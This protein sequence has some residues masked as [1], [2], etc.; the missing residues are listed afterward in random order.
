MKNGIGKMIEIDL[1]VP[2]NENPRVNRHAV[3]AVAKSI[4]E[5]GFAAPIV[6]RSEDNMIICGHTRFLAAQQLKLDRIPV[7]FMDLSLE[8][9]KRL[10][11]ADNKT[12][13]LALWDDERLKELLSSFDVPDLDVLGFDDDELEEMLTIF[14]PPPA[15]DPIPKPEPIENSDFE[16]TLLKGDC[17]ETLKTLPDNSIDAIITDP[18]YHLQSIVD[19]FGGENAAESKYG[20]DGLFQRASKGFMGKTWDGGSIAFS[21]E[22]WEECLRVVKHGG[23]LCAF[24]STRTVFRMGVAIEDSG[25]M[26]RDMVSWIYASGFP[27]SLDISKAIDKHLGAERE[28]I[29]TKKQRGTISNISMNVRDSDV[30]YITK[31][32]TPEA[33]RAVG[34]G[35]ALKPAQEPCIIARKPIEGTNAENFLKYGTG[36]LNIDKARFPYGDPCWPFNNEEYVIN[37]HDDWKGFHLQQENQEYV[38]ESRRSPVGGRWPAN[39]YHCKKAQRSER[40]LGLEHLDIKERF[41]N[42]NSHNGTGKRVDGAPTPTAFNHHPTVKPVKLMQFLVSLVVPKGGIVLDPFGGSGTTAVAAAL[43]KDVKGAIICE[44][45]EE[46][47]ELIEGRVEHAKRIRAGLEDEE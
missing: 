32:A 30:E 12:G 45:T 33:Q 39:I 24:S 13:E 15:P 8:D 35:T 18:P 2:W 7:R 46:Y 31:P 5:F 47:F 36:G 9:A 43:D 17:L 29:G 23:Y 34:I 28:V 42:M 4:K 22:L 26:I 14:D 6:A 19:R 3:N 44:M 21:R 38:Y 10:A 41:S 37:N 20:S 27:K 16:F 1:L 11:I 40:D 25:W